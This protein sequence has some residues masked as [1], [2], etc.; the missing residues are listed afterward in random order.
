[1]YRHGATDAQQHGDGRDLRPAR[2]RIHRYSTDLEWHVPHFE[3]MLY[4][5]ALV[6]RLSSPDPAPIWTGQG[7]VPLWSPEGSF[8]YTYGITE[9]GAGLLAVDVTNRTLTIVDSRMAVTSPLAVA[10]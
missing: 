3:K 7:Q 9:Q 8:F 2:R 1:A 4:D 6:S 10:P 5:Q